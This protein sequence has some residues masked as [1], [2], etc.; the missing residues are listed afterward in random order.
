MTSCITS[1]HNPKIK[2]LLRLH[3]ASER[4]SEGL[5]LV[6][7]IKEIEI[8]LR[9][10]Y[11]LHSLYIN[12]NQS[13]ITPQKYNVQYYYV[14]Q[15]V[16]ERITY[17][18]DK[19]GILAVFRTQYSSLNQLVL[20]TSQPLVI[21]VERVE[22][23]GNLGAIFRT[24]SAA[25]ADAVI[26]CD[27]QTDI[28]NPN[29]IRSSRGC[30]FSVPWSVTDNE[31]AYKWLKE[32]SLYIVSAAITSK[33][34][35]YYQFEYNR[36]LAII[37]GTEADGLSDFWLSHSDEHLIIPMKGTADSLN[38]SVSAAVIIF[39]AIRQRSLL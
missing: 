38:V 23:P 14:S 21:V 22:K 11:T 1:I 3:K 39:E 36:P 18:I 27:S 10:G 35:I 9:A 26:I 24:A 6:E 7:G 15:K 32:N 20:K 4:K 5:F 37:F 13:N 8:A 19:A 12:E 16:Y 31:N 34:K 25:G 30:L 17:G 28:Y 2:Q 29:V 33:A